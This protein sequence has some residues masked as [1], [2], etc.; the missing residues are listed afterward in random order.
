MA[1]KN[2]E[3]QLKWKL[4]NRK[5]LAEYQKKLR[6]D[7]VEKAKISKQKKE[8][9][10]RN[11]HKLLAKRKSNPLFGIWDDIHSGDSTRIKSAINR[12]DEAYDNHSK[13]NN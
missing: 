9:Y 12:L 8:Y 6:T 2:K 5:R 11:K 10:E 4:N 7:P 3:D 1:Y 13:E